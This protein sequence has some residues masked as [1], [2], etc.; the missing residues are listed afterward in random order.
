[1]TPYRILVT[2][3]REG[4]P[5]DMVDR[6]LTMLSGRVPAGQ[7]IVVVHGNAQGVD[8]Y[9]KMWAIRTEGVDHEPHEATWWKN[10]RFNRAAG[11]QRNGLMVRLGADVCVALI[12]PCRKPQCIRKKPHGTHGAS[13]CAEQAVKAGIRT[14]RWRP[15]R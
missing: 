2:G 9:A 8:T 6:T 13:N 3:S 14:L 5:Q 4:V 15:T 7:P 10:G 11:H 1:M 12:A